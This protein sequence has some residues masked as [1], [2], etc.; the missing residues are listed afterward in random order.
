[1]LP[2]RLR[3]NRAFTLIELLVVIAIIAVLVALLL[4]A[5]QHARSAARRAQC[6]SNLH[7]FGIALHSYAQVWNDHLPPISTW[8][9]MDPKSEQRYWFGLVLDPPW[10]PANERRVDVTQGFLWPYLGKDKGVMLCPE[11][12]PSRLRW[13]F[14]GATAGYAYNYI[15]LGPG[16]W[17]DWRSGQLIKPVTIRRAQIRQTINTIAFADSARIR[18]WGFGASAQEPV[19]E[20]NYFLDP[21]SS[22]YSTVHFRHDGLANVLFLAG[23]VRA[24]KPTI[25]KMPPWWPEPADRLRYEFGIFDIGTDDE[26]WDQY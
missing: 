7:Q 8:D 21:P 6:A 24:M 11:F 1:M 10:V 5:V 18:W 4:P 14:Q 13:R 16:I 20:E 25:R 19:A 23:H 2:I 22:N 15:Y 26:L 9:W 12:Q 3:S 17:R